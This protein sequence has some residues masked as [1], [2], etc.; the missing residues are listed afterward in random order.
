MKLDELSKLPDKRKKEWVFL[1]LDA[2]EDRLRMAC[3]LLDSWRRETEDYM[4]I[5]NLGKPDNQYSY[6][7][8]TQLLAKLKSEGLY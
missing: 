2:V 1:Q 5:N 3:E 8:S 6:R 4:L 7:F